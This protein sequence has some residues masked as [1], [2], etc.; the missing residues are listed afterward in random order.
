MNMTVSSSIRPPFWN[1]RVEFL[2]DAIW[3]VVPPGGRPV[4]LQFLVAPRRREGALKFG[5]NGCEPREASLGDR[6]HA[7]AI[8]HHRILAESAVPPCTTLVAATLAGA[9]GRRNP[10]TAGGYPIDA[11][12]LAAAPP[13][14]KNCTK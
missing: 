10:D 8:R 5:G 11:E 12:I 6:K 4:Q 14:S 2:E 7:H 1:L 13:L 9:T 3:N